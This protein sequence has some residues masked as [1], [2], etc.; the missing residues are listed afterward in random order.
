MS[1]HCSVPAGEEAGRRTVESGRVG[2]ACGQLWLGR[3]ASVN[4]DLRCPHSMLTGSE[5]GRLQWEHPSTR[6]WLPD[7]ILHGKEQGALGNSLG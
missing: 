6:P 5:Q 2:K 7:T 3:L 4:G 1:R